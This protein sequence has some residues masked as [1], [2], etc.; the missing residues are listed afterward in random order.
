MPSKQ[1]SYIEIS[2]QDIFSRFG[3]NPNEIPTFL[4]LTGP[5][6]KRKTSIDLTKRQ[7]INLINLY[8]NLEFIFRNLSEIKN[9]TIRNKLNLHKNIFFLRY[10]KLLINKKKIISSFTL[11]KCKWEIAN[12]NNKKIL[13]SHGFF[14]LQPLLGLSE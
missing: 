4:A 9:N 11:D 2:S 6:G 14:S 8:G 1:G 10:S 7:T 13:Q 12:D 5:S 3:I